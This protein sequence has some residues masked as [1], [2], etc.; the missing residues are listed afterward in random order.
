MGGYYLKCLECKQFIKMSETWSINNI[1]P[2][3]CLEH[4]GK[5]VMTQLE[6]GYLSKN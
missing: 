5:G 1:N 2:K 4:I 6:Y 3:K